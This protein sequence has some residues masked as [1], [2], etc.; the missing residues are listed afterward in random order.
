MQFCIIFKSV[1]DVYHTP[2]V[3]DSK[4]QIYHF[5]YPMPHKE[6]VLYT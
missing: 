2:K 1:Y 6:T 5:M 4:V 3:V